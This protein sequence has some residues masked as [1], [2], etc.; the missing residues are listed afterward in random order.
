M[1]MF[2]TVKLES[3]QPEHGIAAGTTLQTKD[4]FAVGASFTITADGRLV[5]HP[6]CYENDPQDIAVSAKPLPLRQLPLEDRQIAYHG[7]I[8]LVGE[9]ANGDHLLELVARF[10]DGR[11]EWLRPLSTY[12]AESLGLLI[13]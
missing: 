9:A 7:D 6:C 10:T 3:A 1:G 4:L 11:L 2:D 12:P 13:E 8:L 5:E